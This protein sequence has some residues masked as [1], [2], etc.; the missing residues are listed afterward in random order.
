MTK[1]EA[2]DA[3]TAVV[4]PQLAR[5]DRPRGEHFEW[6]RGEIAVHFLGCDAFETV[7]ET[8]EDLQ[9]AAAAIRVLSG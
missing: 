8:I 1:D 4:A 7:R 6:V 3:L 5:G 2:L 9:R